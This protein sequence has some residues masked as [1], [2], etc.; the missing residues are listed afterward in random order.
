VLAEVASLAEQGVK[1]VNLLG[2]NVNAYR[3]PMFDG[4]TADLAL[5][6]RA[7]AE[8]DGIGRIRF[9]TSHPLEFSDSLIA[10]YR[11]VPKLANFL[12]LPVQSGSDRI[13]MMMKR[14]YTA[15]MYKEKIAKLRALRPDIC[16]SSDFIVGFPGETDADFA[17]TLQLIE[18]VGFDQSFSFIYS[19]RPGTPAS[20]LFDPTPGAVKHERLATLQ[21]AIN[22]HAAKI[23]EAMVGSTQRILVTGPSKKNPN[24]LT[25]KAEN[26]RQV[27]FAGDSNLIGQFVDVAITAAL[28]NSL[29]A[30]VAAG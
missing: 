2:Q 1:E 16:I 19:K 12:H 17:Q 27:N 21:N 4:G 10:A 24:E 20:N 23:S 9:T 15:A 8:I 6:I 5:L 25:G 13:L 30:R 28:T 18:D 26:M 3:G 22:F 14:N 11:D 7:I 29:R